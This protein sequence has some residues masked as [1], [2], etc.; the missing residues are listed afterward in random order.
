M[1]KVAKYKK[2]VNVLRN[3]C[4]K[5][6]YNYDIETITDKAQLEREMQEFIVG[7]WQLKSGKE[8]S[9]SSLKNALILLYG[10]I[11]QLKQ[12]RIIL[13]HHD[14]LTAEEITLIFN[15]PKVS[16]SHAQGLQYRVFMWM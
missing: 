10:K 9:P 1:P 13:Q 16:A 8:Y 6:G 14:P 2:W 12:N 7:V 11:K 15:H 4:K 5:V 3:W